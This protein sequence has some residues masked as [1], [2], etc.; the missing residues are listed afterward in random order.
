VQASAFGICAST[1]ANLVLA[2][3]VLIVVLDP[4]IR[5]IVIP[6]RKK[7]RYTYQSR[8]RGHRVDT[9]LETMRLDKVLF[10]S[11]SRKRRHAAASLVQLS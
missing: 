11:G 3:S 1:V 8:E 10:R 2:N 5:P 7:V 6:N 4:I 9:T